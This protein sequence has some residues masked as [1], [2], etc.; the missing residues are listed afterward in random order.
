MDRMRTTLEAVLKDYARSGLN[1][2]SY[3]MQSHDGKAFSVI[4]VPADNRESFVSILVRLEQGQ[5]I[6]DQDRNDKPLVDALVEAG[7]PR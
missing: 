6:I 2:N 1:S 4:T 3:L 7:I 5:I